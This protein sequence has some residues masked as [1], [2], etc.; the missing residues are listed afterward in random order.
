[1]AEVQA[2][3]KAAKKRESKAGHRRVTVTIPDESY[4]EL[5]RLASDQMREPN[6]FLSF[7]LKDRIQ[8]MLA[9]YKEV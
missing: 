3:V 1:M 8:S 5:E 4:K 7:M 9:D 2:A 6:N